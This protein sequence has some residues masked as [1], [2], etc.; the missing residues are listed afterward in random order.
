MGERV[1]GGGRSLILGSMGQKENVKK[2]IADGGVGVK[3]LRDLPSQIRNPSCA[4]Q[5]GREKDKDRERR[6]RKKKR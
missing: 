1:Q 6:E 5:E 4:S 2:K 3:V